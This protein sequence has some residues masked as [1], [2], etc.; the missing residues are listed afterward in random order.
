MGQNFSQT[1]ASQVL[2]TQQF[3]EQCAA[4]D[5][6]LKQYTFGRYVVLGSI[7]FYKVWTLMSKGREQGTT[8]YARPY[9]D[10]PELTTKMNSRN[11]FVALLIAFFIFIQSEGIGFVIYFGTS[12]LM[13]NYAIYFAKGAQ[14][15][16][17]TTQVALYSMAVLTFLP[18]C[19]LAYRL[20]NRWYDN[21]HWLGMK[22]LFV[23][24]MVA[25]AMASFVARLH[26]VYHFGWDALVDRVLQLTDYKVIIAALVPPA[27]DALQ[28]LMLVAAS[29]FAAPK[30]SLHQNLLP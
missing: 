27:V 30:G 8:P 10:H 19:A 11:K 22:S 29:S 1:G 12:A 24:L 15:C 16:E 20:Q 28:T 9:C 25:T 2:Q 14:F 13:D 3:Q 23:F 26:L 18:C 4:Y 17:Y 6:T 21:G 5:I 7:V